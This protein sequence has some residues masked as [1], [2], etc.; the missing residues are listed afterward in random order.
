MLKQ[1]TRTYEMPSKYTSDITKQTRKRNETN[2]QKTCRSSNVQGKK[3]R[4]PSAFV[5]W[6]GDLGHGL[7]VVRIGTSC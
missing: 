3:E 6:F 1:I 4:G 5:Q 7:A 2:E